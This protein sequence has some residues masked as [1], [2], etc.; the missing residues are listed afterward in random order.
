[1]TNCGGPRLEAVSEFIYTDRPDAL[2][3]LPLNRRFCVP[4][5]G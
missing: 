1:M 4:P 3:L 2:Q 5:L